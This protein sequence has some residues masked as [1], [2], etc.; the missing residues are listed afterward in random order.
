MVCHALLQ[1]IFS[2]QGSR[3][4]SLLFLRDTLYNPQDKTHCLH[5]L[6]PYVFCLMEHFCC[7]R[8]LSMFLPCVSNHGISV[9]WNAWR[10]GCLVHW[11]F[12]APTSDHKN[13]VVFSLIVN[14]P[15]NGPWSLE[16]GKWNRMT[17]DS[18]FW[19]SI[20]DV[21]LKSKFT[22]WTGRNLVQSLYFIN[23][24]SRGREVESFLTTVGNESRSSA[25]VKDPDSGIRP[26][27]HLPAW[28]LDSLRV[29]ASCSVPSSKWG[30]I[31][32]WPPVFHATRDS[33]LGR[34][35]FHGAEQWQWQRQRSGFRIIQ[36]HCTYCAPVRI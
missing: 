1:E 30:D 8:F 2:T 3:G 12:R 18:W 36:A 26:L 32:Q 33:F 22:F 19:P 13:H 9:N 14:F 23:R 35:S 7:Q 6:F 34:Q 20:Y 28:W 21:I 4:P 27:W 11:I 10:I 15:Q 24:Q 5:L 29:P 25:V 31:R 17:D 16:C